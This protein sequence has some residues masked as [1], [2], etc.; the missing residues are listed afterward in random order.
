[1]SEQNSEQKYVDYFNQNV[2]E[3]QQDVITI[4]E[5]ASITIWDRFRIRFDDPRLLAS[6]TSK[7]YNTIVA[8]LLS[9][10]K[11]YSSFTINI[12]DRLEMGYN[13]KEDEDD[14]K[15]GNYNVFV[16]HL[17]NTKKNNE[18]DDPTAKPIER[19]VQWNTENVIEQ[20]ELIR[21]ISIDASDALKEIDV[22]T[23]TSE[24]IMPIFITVYESLI[25][26]LKI[27]RR[28]TDQFEYEINF[29]SCF[30]I[31]ARETDS[32][33]DD[34]YIRPSIDKK[35][36]IKDDTAASAKYE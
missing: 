35:L 15:V 36:G 25:N 13:T 12:C 27:K 9:L 23:A 19:A 20:P 14:E 17:N 16:R 32:D 24:L 26:F 31:G 7:I 11:D 5:S 8:K 6:V 3:D 18:I 28:E 30:Y 4:C 34:I 33:A 10:K 1:M 29:I 22:N 2:V 21:K